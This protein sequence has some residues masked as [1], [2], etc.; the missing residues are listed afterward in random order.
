M[1][2]DLER[3]GRDRATDTSGIVLQYQSTIL[4]SLSTVEVAALIDGAS[5]AARMMA[6]AGIRF[7]HPDASDEELVARLAQLTLEPGLARRVYPV[8]AALTDSSGL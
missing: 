8:L 5:R 4:Q 6:L 7:R 3:P 1:R 2:S